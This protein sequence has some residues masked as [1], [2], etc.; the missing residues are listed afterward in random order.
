MSKNLKMTSYVMRQE[1]SRNIPPEITASSAFRPVMA[2]L[3]LFIMVALKK[4]PHP[5][6]R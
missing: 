4:R 1:I 5:K 2:E 3:S 6:K